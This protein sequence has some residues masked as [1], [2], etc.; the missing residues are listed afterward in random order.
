MKSE[1]DKI[2]DYFEKLDDEHKQIN[3]KLVYSTE[4][5]IFGTSDLEVVYEFF[6]KIKPSPTDVFVD[7]GSGDGRVVLVANLFCR[8]VGVEFDKELVKNSKAHAKKLGLEVEFLCEDYEEFDYSQANIIYSYADHFFTPAF[9][10]RLK[11]EFKGQ[12]YVYQ[13]VFLPDGVKKG[14]KIWAKDTPII[15]YEF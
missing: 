12:L 1:F 11:K 15:S 6:K 8:G 4:K 10:E 13:G 5:G 9:I 14:P 7:I 3:K 2:V